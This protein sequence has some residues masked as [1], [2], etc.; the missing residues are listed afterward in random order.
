MKKPYY[1][2]VA[3]VLSL[4]VT[5][6]AAV[7]ADEDGDDRL[8]PPPAIQSNMPESLKNQ[9]RMDY[10]NRLKN[11]KNNQDLRN[12]ALEGKKMMMG[13]TTMSS[14]IKMQFKGN[15]DRD[16]HDDRNKVRLNASSTMATSSREMFKEM[17]ENREEHKKDVRRDVFEFQK[18]HIIEQLQHALNNLKQIRTRILARITK[19]EQSGRNMTE[20][21]SLLTL[22]DSKISI[23]DQSISALISLNIGTSTA[24]STANAS[25]TIDLKK[26]RELANSAI[27]TIKDAQRAL[28]AVV[29]AIAHNM[30][31][32]LGEGHTAT[33]TATST[34]TTATST[35]TNSTA[36]STN[37]TATS[38]NNASTTT[39]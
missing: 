34:N 32:K 6:P 17:M 20:A 1:L 7:R 19:A 37:S 4:L 14:S 13:S 28:N 38:T 15:D 29:V 22:A 18:R 11:L 25:T 2:I 39:Q 16:D 23:A 3:L 10:E 31:L 35:S 5:V 21:R 24:T 36:T 30:G 26:P 33:T 27:K 12:M 9:L 8:P